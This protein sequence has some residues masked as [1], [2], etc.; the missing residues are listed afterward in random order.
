VENRDRGFYA[1][2]AVT[3]KTIWETNL[4]RSVSAGP[5]T[6]MINGKQCVSIKAGSVLFTFCLR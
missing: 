5:M 4:G 6:W 1:P 2:D 3:G